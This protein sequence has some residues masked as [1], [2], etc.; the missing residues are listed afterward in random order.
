[1]IT[2]KELAEIE[3]D[4]DRVPDVR[5]RSIERDAYKMAWEI[6]RLNARLH[7]IGLAAKTMVD[8]A[9]TT[10]EMGAPAYIPVAEFNEFAASVSDLPEILHPEKVES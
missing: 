10:G 4:L 6:R 1:V 8:A 9:G 3:A 7:R 5:T 2:D